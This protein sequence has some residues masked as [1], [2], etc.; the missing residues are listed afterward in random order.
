MPSQAGGWIAAVS[1]RGAAGITGG[2]LGPEPETALELPDQALESAHTLVQG[3]VLAGHAS[4]ASG[5]CG[6]ATRCGRRACQRK[7]AELT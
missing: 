6:I 2:S 1:A 7:P 4:G 5:L 3:D